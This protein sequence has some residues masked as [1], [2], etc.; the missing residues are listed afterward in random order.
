MTQHV[1]FDIRSMETDVQVHEAF[2]IISKDGLTRID[3]D[4]SLIGIINEGPFKLLA[5]E[6]TALRIDLEYLCVSMPEW[7]IQIT[8]V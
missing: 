2:A 7:M 6:C 3:K 1:E 5:D 4:R 8:S